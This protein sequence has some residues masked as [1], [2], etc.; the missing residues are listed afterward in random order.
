MEEVLLSVERQHAEASEAAKARLESAGVSRAAAEADQELAEKTLIGLQDAAAESLGT[1]D[2]TRAPTEEAQAA[3]AAAREAQEM[4]DAELEAAGGKRAEVLRLKADVLTPVRDWTVASD[5]E[6]KGKVAELVAF[7]KRQGFDATL[8]GL[9]PL[10]LR[11][12][13]SKRTGFDALGIQQLEEALDTCLAALEAE[14][15]AVAAGAAQQ[16][17]IAASVEAAAAVKDA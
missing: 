13:P 16:A 3:L 7:S 8:I 5:K 9:I 1:A 15:A 17:A 11:Q 4:G 2:S 14:S 6:A 10:A 12:P